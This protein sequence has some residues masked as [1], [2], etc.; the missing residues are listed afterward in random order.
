MKRRDYRA[1]LG[2]RFVQRWVH[3]KDFDGR[4]DVV[5]TM[6]EYIGNWEGVEKTYRYAVHWVWNYETLEFTWYDKFPAN[7]I[8][9]E[10]GKI[11]I[12]EDLWNDM[13]SEAFKFLDTEEV[14]EIIARGIVLKMD[15]EKNPKRIT[16]TSNESRYS[17]Y[18]LIYG[19]KEDRTIKLLESDNRRP[20]EG[21]GAEEGHSRI[22]KSF[23][24]AACRRVR[25]YL[26]G[27]P[28]RSLR[29]QMFEFED[30]NASG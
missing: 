18:V 9:A 13:E 20:K 16:A 4:R 30:S 15:D 11:S 14:R 1:E 22:P 19:V 26:A 29:Q 23:C 21:D 7:D 10:H 17:G 8:A 12:P 27:L 2:V 24:K 25:D 28:C 6:G 3:L 5:E